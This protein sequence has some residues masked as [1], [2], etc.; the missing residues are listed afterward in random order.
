[1]N[2]E[3]KE[4]QLTDRARRMLEQRLEELDEETIGRL[5]EA[6][7]KA[8][9][10]PSPRRPRWIAMGGWAAAAASFLLVVTLWNSDNRTPEAPGIF[11]DLE[12]LSTKEDMEFIEDLDFYLWL[13]DEQQTG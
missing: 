11:E 5:Y 1:M 12:L 8:L 13:D 4:R 10:R 9:H 3:G 7:Q 2:Q 6:R